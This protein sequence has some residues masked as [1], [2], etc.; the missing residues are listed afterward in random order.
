M[1]SA[2]RI[3]E[4]LDDGLPFSGV[5]LA[6]DNLSTPATPAAPAEGVCVENVNNLYN[7]APDFR[8]IIG[9]SI[10]IRASF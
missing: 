5:V 6:R 8:D 7:L 4:K 3:D 9:C 10:R 1:L 2:E